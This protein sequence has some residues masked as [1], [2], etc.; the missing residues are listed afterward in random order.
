MKQ[1]ISLDQPFVYAIIS[2]KGGVGKSMAAVNTAVM[3]REQGYRVALLDADF[4]LANC[5][6]L[7]NEPVSATVSS[8]MKGNCGIEDLATQTA[9][10]TLI[11][12]ANEPG[13]NKFEASLVMDALDQ[14]TDYLKQNHDFIIIDTPAGAGEMTLWA[15]DAAHA[16]VLILVD[17]PT[18]ISDVYRLCKYVFNIDPGYK[19]ADIVNYAK[20]EQSAESTHHRFNNIL[21]Y[22]LQQ[23]TVNFGTITASE[24]I[25]TAVQKQQPLLHINKE[26]PAIQEFEYI[27]QNM[28]A[29]ARNAQEVLLKTV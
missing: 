14:V 1:A 23:Q 26:S 7:L 15:L 12:G 24:D 16:G 27:A 10:I 28:V 18:S 19:F 4:G 17:E 22:F 29:Y 13:E 21:N 2:G 8:W 3:L 9:G 25:R 11:T 5:A 6:A 20:N